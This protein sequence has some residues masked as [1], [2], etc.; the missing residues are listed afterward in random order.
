MMA[1]SAKITPLNYENKPPQCLLFL[2]VEHQRSS[3]GGITVFVG[4]GR[5]TG[6]TRQPEVTKGN[7]KASILHETCQKPTQARVHV[8]GN[9]VLQ[10]QLRNRLNIVHG[11]VREVGRGTGKL[12]NPY[13]TRLHN[14][15]VEVNY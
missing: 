9:V 15:E 12:Q 2:P 10:P 4:V 6:H 13:L 1:I 14:A 11:A 8:H 7:G 3:F 5:N